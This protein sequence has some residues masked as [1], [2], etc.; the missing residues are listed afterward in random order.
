MIHHVNT[1]S[2]YNSCEANI[3][4]FIVIFHPNPRFRINRQMNTSTEEFIPKDT[5]PIAS[6]DLPNQILQVTEMKNKESE[7]I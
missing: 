6:G 2:L 4:F 5:Y 7:A 1:R 3:Y